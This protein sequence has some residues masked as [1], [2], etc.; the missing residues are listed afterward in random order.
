VP[1]LIKDIIAA[2]AGAPLTSGSS[3]LRNNIPDHDSVLV[4]RLKRAG[5]VILGKTN[6]P[7]LG[8]QPATEPR[9]F[10]PTRNP[11]NPART[12]GG[13][14]GGSA[15]AVAARM[16]PMAHANDGGGS[17]RIPA[18]CCGVFGFKPTRG[19]TSLG[20]DLG[21]I[22]GGL[23]V[24]H[25]VT[26]SVRDSAALLDATAGPSPGD[27]YRAAP[28][29]RP[30]LEE[31]RTPPGKLRI[32]L[33]KNAFTGTPVHADCV[34]AAEEAARLCSDLGHEVVEDFPEIKSDCVMQMFAAIWAAGCAA[35]IEGAA[36]LTGRPP[37]EDQFEPFT[38][39]LYQVGRNV[40]A[41]QFLL[42]QTQLQQ[43]SRQVAAFMERYD[44]LLSPVL[45]SPPVPQGWFNMPPHDY[46]EVNQR[47]IAFAPFALL[48]NITGQPAMSV[49]LCWNEEN[50]P[51]GTHF[52]GRYE[53][54]AVLF[55]LAA[56]LEKAKP[57]AARNPPFSA[58]S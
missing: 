15:A 39:A 20:P 22:M 41:S 32:A 44:V 43:T 7:E 4:S 17:I 9:L 31:T 54:E 46:L 3:F 51:I 16:V 49:P 23:V 40:T 13:S 1:Y 24:E 33:A 56:Q 28:P 19:R 14:S 26:V 27:P 50:L 57:W 34:R 53:D 35:A 45:G 21:E 55:R 37:T 5:L 29:A 12:A 25:A 42:A 2:Y 18:S 48:F 11:W 47:M 30:Y 52:A 10:G 6:T 58:A 8:L 38:W 36:H